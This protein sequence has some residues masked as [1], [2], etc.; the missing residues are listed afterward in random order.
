[1]EHLDKLTDEYTEF[2]KDNNLPGLS[3]EELLFECNLKEWQNRYVV[4]FIDRWNDG[5]N[6]NL[7]KYRLYAGNGKVQRFIIES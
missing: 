2:L 7:W 5:E 1:M 6:T 4:D 3:A